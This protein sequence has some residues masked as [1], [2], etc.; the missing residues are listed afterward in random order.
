MKT[1]NVMSPHWNTPSL[2]EWYR[3]LRQ[4]HHWTVWQ[5]IRYALWLRGLR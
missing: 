4:Y 1:D 3:I 2:V 5:A